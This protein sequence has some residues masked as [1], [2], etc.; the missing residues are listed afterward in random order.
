MIASSGRSQGG[1]ARCLEDTWGRLCR[2]SL[3]VEGKEEREESR[4]WES[5][6]NPRAE[7]GREAEKG[8][9]RGHEAQRMW[10]RGASSPLLW[11]CGEWGGAA[12]AMG[13]QRTGGQ[14]GPGVHVDHT[15][16]SV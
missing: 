3:E 9:V 14:Q 7:R 16:L 6:R 5:V 15:C 1:P 13:L 12:G 8:K 11:P 2:D 10:K 4:C